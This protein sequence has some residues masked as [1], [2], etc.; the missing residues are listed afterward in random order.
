MT[1]A[2]I[3]AMIKQVWE[4]PMSEEEKAAAKRGWDGMSEWQS[5]SFSELDQII[6]AEEKARKAK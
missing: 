4:A 1:E 3:K 6:A 5:M 2:E